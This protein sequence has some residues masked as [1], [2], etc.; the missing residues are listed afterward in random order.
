MLDEWF[1]GIDL[2][3]AAEHGAFYKIDGAWH[4]NMKEKPVWN[5]EEILDI[6]QRTIDK[7][8]RSELEIK[9]T[10]SMALPKFRYMVS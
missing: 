4:Q 5:D 10:V 1:E 9:N 2:D 7:T 6:I 8:P 3:L